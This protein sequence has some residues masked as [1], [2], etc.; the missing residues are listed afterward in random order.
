MKTPAAH[1]AGDTQERREGFAPSRPL[2]VV[3]ALLSLA[4]LVLSTPGLAPTFE[5]SRE[6]IL[7]GELWRLVT[8]H[9]THWSTD[10]LTWDLGAFALLGAMAE[11]SGHRRLCALLL[12]T[13]LAI[14][15][16]LLA[17]QPALSLYR[18]L[19]GLDSA[20]FVAVCAALLQTS[21]RDR[22]RTGATIA[23]L[24]VLGFAAKLGREA[25]T[26]EA[27]FV[28]GTGTVA[29]A[30]LAHGVGA[31]VGLASFALASAVARR[32]LLTS[33]L[34]WR[35]TR[36]AAVKP[37]GRQ[38][39]QRALVTTSHPFLREARTRAPYPADR[40]NSTV[41]LARPERLVRNAG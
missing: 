31:A 15:L 27:L 12:A 3:T 41:D 23:A 17:L 25:L 10:H 7:G 19:S 24:F 4:T 37:G 6:A 34:M 30:P 9:F 21:L 29:L 20:M 33:S 39:R 40:S 28:A 32:A 5:F 35:G 22:D 18:G 1:R 2:P 36:S 38:L 8:G 11:R 13:S 26:G 16:A 14:S